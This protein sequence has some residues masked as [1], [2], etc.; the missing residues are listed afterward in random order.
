MVIL[1]FLL[2]VSILLYLGSPMEPSKAYMS[3]SFTV[4]LLAV[5]YYYRSY[6]TAKNDVLKKIKIFGLVSVFVF[7]FFVVFFQRDIDYIL[8]ICD[9]DEQRFYDLVWAGAPHV[10]CKSL[11]LS[12]VALISFLIGAYSIRTRYNLTTLYA[13][14]YKF[15]QPKYVCYIGY[16]LILIY[17][18]LSGFNA[19]PDEDDNRGILVLTQAVI[20]A[21]ISI[22]CYKY[23][24]EVNNIQQLW[25]YL[26]AP[27][28]LCAIYLVVILAT[29]KRGGAVKVGFILIFL[30]I[31]MIKVR[32]PYLRIMIFG[33]LG[34]LAMSLIGLLRFGS[35]MSVNDA[36][37]YLYTFQS[38]LP[39]TGELAGSV[40]TLHVAIDNVPIK[41]P[42]NYGTSFFPGFS[43]L[44]PGF[45]RLL[46]LTPFN[47]PNSEDIITRLYFGGA[48]PDWGWG[49]GSSAVAD[50]YISFGLIGVIFV[51]WFL[52]R[53]FRKLEIKVLSMQHSPYA[54]ALAI[55]CYSQIFPLC[56]GPFSILFLS[57][58]Y[59]VIIIYL[60]KINTKS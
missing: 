25:Q 40:N 14:N 44:I 50:A 10:I 15:K 23:K 42:Y 12:S 58:S 34:M 35:T 18:G 36:I 59:S 55:C 27:I 2:L 7:A 8:G 28:I 60:F 33:F 16:F 53:F 31:Y 57:L 56:R 45:S 32:I 54:L 46:A 30:Y 49:L 17:L 26:R 51:F 11:C 47:F 39:M 5:V 9:P 20:I 13:A 19:N 24:N 38:I 29:G 41:V 43:V 6:K 52:G 21:A 37:D 22:Y 3:Y 4:C 1:V 48:V